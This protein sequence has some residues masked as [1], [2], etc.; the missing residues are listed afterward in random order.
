MRKIKPAVYPTA[1]AKDTEARAYVEDSTT[2]QGQR[3]E[4][5]QHKKQIR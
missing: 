1:K 2:R 5:E 3:Q 4:Q